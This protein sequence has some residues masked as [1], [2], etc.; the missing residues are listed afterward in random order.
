[1]FLIKEMVDEVR[2]TGEGGH[3]LEL[4]M[5]LKGDGDDDE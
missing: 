3:T 1:L 5:R 2:E 4:T